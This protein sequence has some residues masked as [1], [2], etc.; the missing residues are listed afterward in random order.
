MN[1]DY[2]LFRS[3]ELSKR[4]FEKG[5]CQEFGVGKLVALMQEEWIST[6]VWLLK[7]QEV[8]LENGNFVCEGTKSDHVGI[9]VS[10]LEV[11]VWKK[12]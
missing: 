5:H 2:A 1:L 3:L 6:V 4:Y 12:E 8:M 11:N 10:N 9:Q 7:I